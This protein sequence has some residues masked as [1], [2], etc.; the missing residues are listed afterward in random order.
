[1]TNSESTLERKHRTVMAFLR[2]LAHH[3]DETRPKA[4]DFQRQL[5]QY[6]GHSLT[7]DATQ[8]YVDRAFS[9]SAV[10]SST[11]AQR[12]TR[13]QHELGRLGALAAHL[14]ALDEQLI[15]DRA[16]VARAR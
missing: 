4:V 14:H 11:P 7:I 2:Y 15:P 12:L 5:A 9:R 8:Y 1:M 13:E 3:S 16:P 10:T 6:L